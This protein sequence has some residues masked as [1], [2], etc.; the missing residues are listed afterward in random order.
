MVEELS[1]LVLYRE[2]LELK[3]HRRVP[4]ISAGTSAVLPLLLDGSLPEEIN[5][6]RIG[7]A[8][9]LGTDPA[10]GE[11]LPGLRTDV[12]TLEAEVVEI[13][14]KRLV[15][16]LE[17]G[18]TPFES[19]ELDHEPGARGYRAIVTV[20]QVDTDVAGL[21]PIDPDH[22]I[23]GA[24]SDVT[25]VNVGEEPPKINVGD[26]L[27][28]RPNYAAFVRL[29]NNPYTQVQLSTSSNPRSKTGIGAG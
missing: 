6:F 1:Q 3:F 25:V 13:K 2:L 21:L 26:T 9:L 14:E 7:E 10:T 15:S 16:T 4:L 5:H 20:G 19:V 22:T 12:V 24:S 17:A 11:S 23:A 28:F 29:M 18:E 27:L 8:L